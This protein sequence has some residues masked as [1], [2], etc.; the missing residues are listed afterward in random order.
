[1]VESDTAPVAAPRS[2]GRRVRR[3]VSI[4]ATLMAV[5]ACADMSTPTAIPAPQPLELAAGRSGL[6]INS[7]YIRMLAGA[8]SGLENDKAPFKAAPASAPA[9]SPEA[10]P[11]AREPQGVG[12]KF[13]G[14]VGR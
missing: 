10:Q 4:A 13:K 1:M 2:V 7:W 6:S 11:P 12:R 3:V 9:P 14:I 8:L 5:A